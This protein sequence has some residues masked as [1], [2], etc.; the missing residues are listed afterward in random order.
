M[1]SQLKK[2]S[3]T[4]VLKLDVSFLVVV[5]YFLIGKYL[6][7]IGL[8]KHVEGGYAFLLLFLLL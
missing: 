7:T 6:H 2:D 5:Q 4:I 1:H 3:E 8:K